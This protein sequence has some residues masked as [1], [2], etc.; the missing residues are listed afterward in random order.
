MKRFDIK[1]LEEV[2]PVKTEEELQSYKEYVAEWKE[3]T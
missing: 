2:R 1:Q 3:A